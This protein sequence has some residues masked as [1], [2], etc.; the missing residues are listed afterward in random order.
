[1]SVEIL[2][3]KTDKIDLP[4]ALLQIFNYLKRPGQ[5]LIVTVNPEFILEAQKN[6]EFRNALNSA[7]LSTADGVG[8]IFAAR[9]LKNEKLFRVTGVDLTRSLLTNCSDA[10]IYLLGGAEGVAKAVR[11]RYPEVR[12]VGAE[13]GGKLKTEKWELEDNEAVI[14]RINDSGANLLLVAFGQVKQELWIK[15]NLANMPNIKVAIGIGGTFDFLAG[16]MRRAPKWMRQLGLEW[17]YR[18]IKEPRRWK[19]IWRAVVVFPLTILLKK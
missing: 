12:I 15:A 16:R 2:G 8:L 7:R 18:L 9:I 5:N 11:K 4:G 17:L 6:V 13:S 14:K 3:V 1:M 19:R 10:K